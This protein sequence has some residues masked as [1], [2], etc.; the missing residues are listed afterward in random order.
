MAGSFLRS[1]LWVKDSSVL[2]S[3]PMAHHHVVQS[4]VVVSTYPWAT[5]HTSLCVNYQ[6]AAFHSCCFIPVAVTTPK[7]QQE[8]VIP[9]SRKLAETEGGIAPTFRKQAGSSK[10]EQ[11]PSSVN[12]KSPC[13]NHQSLCG[14]YLGLLRNGGGIPFPSSAK[15]LRIKTCQNKIKNFP[16]YNI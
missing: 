9:T 14:V 7:Q 12:S 10:Q 3:C 15:R 2:E 5:F 6:F 1:N 8:P 4:C 16:F 13:N 11:K